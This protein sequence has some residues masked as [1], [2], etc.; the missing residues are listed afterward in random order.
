M[1]RLRLNGI[2]ELGE[3]LLTAL[4]TREATSMLQEMQNMSNADVITAWHSIGPWPPYDS[5]LIMCVYEEM[6]RRRL[7]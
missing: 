7:L 6:R 3:E 5:A 4:A 1:E 2:E